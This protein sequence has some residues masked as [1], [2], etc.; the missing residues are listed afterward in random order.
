MNEIAFNKVKQ[1]VVSILPNPRTRNICLTLLCK[2]INQANMLGNAKWGTHYDKNNV[3]LLVGSLIVFTIEKGCIWLALDL[4]SL[5]ASENKLALLQSTTSWQW[6]T[7]DYPNYIKVPSK[8]GYYTPS[9]DHPEIWPVVEELHFEFIKKAAAKYEQLRSDS[10]TKHSPELLAYLRHE[11]GQDVPEPTYSGIESYDFNL[12][13]EISDEGDL[14]EGSKRKVTINAY[15]RNPKARQ[16]CISHYGFH[17]SVCE[18]DFGK[19]Y[20]D[21][22]K[23]FI[24][25]HHLKPLADIGEEYEIDPISDLRPVC[26]N[27]HAIIHRRDPPYTIE[28]V[29]SFLKLKPFK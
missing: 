9:D 17:C 5:E 13:E 7:D 26:P 24:H 2:T 25:V 16:K 28:E 19:I 11:L 1:V 14:Y 20:G 10:Q 3:R 6:D 18:F 21:I 29:K 27:C 15:E 22:G 23:G 8:N 12:P 4:P